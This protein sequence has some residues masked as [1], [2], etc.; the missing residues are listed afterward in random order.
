M[1]HIGQKV[2]CIHDWHQH[3]RI[4]A[5]EVGDPL[6]EKGQVYTIRAIAKSKISIGYLIVWL[7]E[8][9]CS[10]SRI[11]ERGYTSRAFRPVVSQ[12]T[13]ISIFTSMLKEDHLCL[14][15]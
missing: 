15:K 2:V 8:F 12:K 14:V 5:A 13:D 4:R 6:P 1:F 9:R 11:G 7:E 10:H 3:T